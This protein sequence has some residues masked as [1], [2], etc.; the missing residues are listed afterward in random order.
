VRD[1]PWLGS[2]ERSGPSEQSGD[3]LAASAGR[4]N[5][6]VDPLF[7]DIDG[8]D[9][10]LLTVGDNDYRLAAGS[11]CNDAGDNALVAL[12]S[13][14]IDGDGNVGELTPLDL[15]LQPRFVE[16]PLAPNVGSGTPPLVDLGCYE[17]P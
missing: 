4:S 15:L 5:L 16:D 9:N 11:P 3:G 14:D 6:D 12:D 17:H 7:V 10:N 8:P 2:I 13:I 1:Q